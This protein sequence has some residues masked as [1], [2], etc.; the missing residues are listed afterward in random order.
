MIPEN[1]SF[2]RVVTKL[3]KRFDFLVEKVGGPNR[4]AKRLSEYDPY[5]GESEGVYH[6]ANAKQGRAGEEP[7]LRIVNAL[8]LL[9]EKSAKNESKLASS[10]NLK[11]TYVP[12]YE[13]T[14]SLKAKMDLT[15]NQS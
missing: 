12:K 13:A 1:E 4:L 6:V 7:M 15:K 11:N 14:K 3:R 8:E 10:P 9:A 2:E 5:F